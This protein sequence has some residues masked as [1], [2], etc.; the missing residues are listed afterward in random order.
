MTNRISHDT[1]KKESCIR[2]IG[3]QSIQNELLIDFIEKNMGIKCSSHNF[4]IR[5]ITRKG[6]DRE[7]LL[8]DC[9]DKKNMDK[10]P[11]Y[12][13]SC[14]PDDPNA[15]LAFFNLNESFRI[16]EEKKALKNG[17]KGFFYKKDSLAL[18]KKGIHAIL[19][20]ELWFSRKALMQCLR[21]SKTRQG[22]K[23][24][25]DERRAITR[26]EKEVLAMIARG[27]CNADIAEQLHISSNTVRTHVYNIYQKIAV[28]NRFEARLWASENLAAI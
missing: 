15:Y 9:H 14:K 8:V 26:R 11:G 7:L 13:I 18:F 21:D 12:F 28:K 22:G 10:W 24:A 5:S 25:E 19:G 17:V 3:P 23:R 1:I 27:A 6:C 16:D 2:I 20:G 4:N